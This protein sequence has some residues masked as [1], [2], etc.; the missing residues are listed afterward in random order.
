MNS[1]K[2][3]ANNVERSLRALGSTVKAKSSARFFKTGKGQYGEGDLFFGVTV[4]EQRAVAMRFRDLPLREISS[5]LRHEVHE[6]RLVAILI[7]VGQY[8][9]GD[10]RMKDRIADF[11]LRNARRINNWDLVDSSAPHII[12]EY[13]LRHGSDVLFRLARSLNLWERRIAV[14]ATLRPINEG[15]F[16]DTLR[17]AE[18]YLSDGH[19][20]IH[21]ATGWM[22]REVGKRS[23]PTL[24]RFLDSHAVRMPRTMLRYA[25]EHYPKKER[26]HYLGLRMARKKG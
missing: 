26:N 5:L 24:S 19:D 12:G 2:Q 25:L 15:V 13:T 22:L 17:I 4:P 6:C 18:A 11:Y 9:R 3:N 10:E 20:L 1:I 7:L 8:R 14:V 23:R 21:K 16:G